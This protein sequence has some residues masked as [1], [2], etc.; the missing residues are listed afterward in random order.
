MMHQPF[1]HHVFGCLEYTVTD[2]YVK[3]TGMTKTPSN[4]VPAFI[5]PVIGKHYMGIFETKE[6]FLIPRESGALQINIS[7]KDNIEK[8]QPIFCLSG[9]FEAWEF[10]IKPDKSGMLQVTIQVEEE[11]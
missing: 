10:V 3:I 7:N 8:P 9:G 11:K 2:H 4:I 1:D 6:G 5:L